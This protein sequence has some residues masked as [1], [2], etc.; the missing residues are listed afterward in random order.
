MD[1]RLLEH[2]ELELKHVRGMAGEFAHEFPKVAGRLALD[3]FK[4]AD[5]YVERLLEGFAY[6]SARVQLQIS[7][8]FPVF[9]RHLL[10]QVYP[11]YLA[12]IPSMAMVQFQPNLNDASLAEGFPI[13]RGCELRGHRVRDVSTRC[14]F[15]TAHDVTLW[16]LEIA[17]AEYFDREGPT[18]KIPDLREI[19]AG[20]RIRLR[21][22]A[23]L[24]FDQLSLDRLPIYLRSFDERAFTLYEQLFANTCKVLTRPT[25]RQAD[26][27]EVLEPDTIQRV[28]F[29]EDEALFPYDA[30][31]FHGY[32]LVHEY[33]AFPQRYMSVQFRGLG[34]SLSQCKENEIELVVLFDRSER[35]LVNGFDKSDFAL[36]CSP[37]INLLRRRADRIHI[38]DRVHEHHVVPDRSRPMDLEVYKIERLVGFGADGEGD[39]EFVPFFSMEDSGGDLR[40]RAYYT[41]RREPRQ[42]SARQKREGARSPSYVGSEAFVSLVDASQA[43]YRHNLRELAPELL[44][45]NRDLPLLLPIQVGKTDFTMEINAPVPS[46][47]CIAGPTKPKPSL[48]YMEGEAAWRLINHLSLNYL[49]LSN[50]SEYQGAAA[51]RDLLQLYAEEHDVVAQSQIEGVKSIRTKQRI[52]RLPDSGPIAVG[53]ALEATV[54]FDEAKFEGSGVFLLGAVLEE[55]F[56]KYV[57]INSMTETAIHSTTRGEIYRWP[58]R[59]GRRHTI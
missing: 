51:L 8:Q 22:T 47:R 43:P 37:A 10:E 14:I 24:T 1:P 28:G 16:P 12:P 29:S 7:S 39:Q 34:R 23:G 17:E 31:S 49:T 2:Y 53:R 50:S 25:G 20:L 44:C 21:C 26:W 38:S 56:R 58:V 15:R 45:T 4:C 30:R 19:R 27:Y 3:E 48:A 42:L 5:P 54:E 33:F 46:I 36:F 59:M 9:T 32:R 41:M 18:I 57:S 6:L 40:P 11:H 52:R 35:R 55:F 13:R